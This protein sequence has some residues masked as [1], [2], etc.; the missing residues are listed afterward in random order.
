MDK[1]ANNLERDLIQ[2]LVDESCIDVIKSNNDHV[3]APVRTVSASTNESKTKRVWSSLD[4]IE[5]NV[6]RDP[7][8]DSH[9]EEI[10][11]IYDVCDPVRTVVDSTKERLRRIKGQV[12]AC[13]SDPTNIFKLFTSHCFEILLLEQVFHVIDNNQLL[14]LR[15]GTDGQILERFPIVAV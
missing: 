9:V 12:S 6:G 1:T 11:S 8:A 15:I 2:N 3:C 10:G 7:V 13:L 4:K 14:L 5:R